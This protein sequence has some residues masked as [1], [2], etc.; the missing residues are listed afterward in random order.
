[1]QQRIIER[2]EQRPEDASAWRMLAKVQ[3]QNRERAAAERSLRTAIELEPGN[4]AAHHDLG[5][6]LIENKVEQ[7]GLAE[8]QQVIRLAP[9]TEYAKSAETYLELWGVDVEPELD[10]PFVSLV[11]FEAGEFDGSKRREETDE[12][13]FEP[14]KEPERVLNAS[15]DVGFQYNSNVALAPTSRQLVP[16]TRESFQLLLSPDLQWTLSESENTRWGVTYFG[17][18]TFN[19]GNFRNFNLESY[20][21]GVFWEKDIFD[22]PTIWV[23]RLSY[24]FIYDLF[25]GDR[26]GNRHSL[27]ASTLA[28]WDDVNSTYGY[29]AADWSSFENPG[30]TPSLTS[31]DGW[32]HTIGMNH[33]WYWKENLYRSFTVGGDLQT[34]DTDGSNYRYHGIQLYV[35][36]LFVPA[37]SWELTLEAGAGF[38]DYYDFSGT[39]SRDEFNYRGVI[40][41]EKRFNDH[42]SLLTFFRYQRFNSENSLYD[43]DQYLAGVLSRFDF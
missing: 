7:E 21:P 20:Q 43:A 37:E 12:P 4:A 42:F 28:I 22:G 13:T 17:Q 38:R 3:L 33:E 2:V 18:W 25:D 29:Y 8:L 6:L 31:Q 26:F 36:S 40:E 41:L 19:E 35:E 9:E 23:P 32:S 39:P 5:Q 10:D 1:M 34:V 15:F 11:G 27:T 14:V 24:E 16:G 30:V